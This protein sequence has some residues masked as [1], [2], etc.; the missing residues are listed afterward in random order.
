[1]KRYESWGRY[2]KT[3]VAKII[4]IA[5]R[6]A[7]PTIDK[8]DRPV[9]AFG[10]GRSYGDVCLNDNGILLDTSQLSRLIAFDRE[11]GVFACEAGVTLVE[12][13]DIIVPTGWFLPVTPGTKCVSVG[14][15]IAN[16]VHGKNHHR[17][18]TFGCHVTRFELLRS[19]GERLLCSPTEN[20][21]MFRATIG[22]LG[23][24]GII[25]W[26]EFGLK[27]IRNPFIALERIRFESLEEFLDLSEQSDRDY[28]YT[29]AWVDCLAQGRKLGRGLFIRGN[30]DDSPIEKQRTAKSSFSVPFDFPSIA[31]NGFTM[32]AFNAA[33]LRM[34]L[35]K[36]IRK[37]VS[38]D[39]FFYPLDA[40]KNWNR[41]YGRRGF[42]QYQC[43]IPGESN[44][45][46]IKEM[47]VRTS[48]AGQGS[49]LAVLKRF[50][51]IPS[52]GMMSFPRSGL[53]LCLDFPYQGEKTLTL[54]EDFDYIVSQARGA[55]YP[56]KDAR[57]AAKSFA[58]YFPHWR[59]FAR[60][61]DSNFSS[62]F[63]RRVTEP[64]NGSK[65]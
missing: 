45:A 64:L 58:I 39:T 2:P 61:V 42:L 40:V 57:M 7:P 23:L 8:F 24:T 5:W 15:A 19:S 11:R 26:A 34:Q 1:M 46:E 48:R 17:A 25:L 20:S 63:W 43:V 6:S 27:R 38:C 13:L 35:S 21:D 59:E 36:T 56:A 44:S 22:G 30:H 29:V 55:V 62:S 12:I 65:P 10:Q 9:L 16:D 31:L 14:G 52:P 18:G 54:L 41:L 47:L 51:D 28:E 33:Y 60:Y 4:P 49:F 53:T 3:E 50:G 37:T 32:R